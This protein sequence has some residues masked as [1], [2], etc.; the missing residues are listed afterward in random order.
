MRIIDWSSYV[1]SSALTGSIVA[2]PPGSASNR[3]A[4]VIAAGLGL[5]ATIEAAGEETADVLLATLESAE[6]DAVLI[7]APLGHEAVAGVSEAA[8]DRKSPRLNSSH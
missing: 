1:C 3:L 7:V 6:A 8:G 4:P 5:E 2:G